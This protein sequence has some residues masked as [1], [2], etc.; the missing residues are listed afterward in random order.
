MRSLLKDPDFLFW[1]HIHSIAFAMLEYGILNHA[2]F[3]VI[4]GEIGSGKTALIRH[5]LN[6]L[7]DS[8]SVGVI[9]M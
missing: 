1:G 2:G 3:T 5:L 9:V 6:S 8:V 4:T 7:D